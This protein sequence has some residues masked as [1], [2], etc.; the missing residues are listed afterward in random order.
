[1]NFLSLKEIKFFTP[2]LRKLVTPLVSITILVILFFVSFKIGF[3]K[4]SSQKEEIVGLNKNI[5]ILKKKEET[6]SIVQKNIS[7]SIQFFSMAIPASNPSLSI[8]SQIKTQSLLKGLIFENLKGGGESKGKS[9]SKVDI[10]FDLDG[11]LNSVLSFLQETE[12]FAPIITLEKIKLNQ[13]G[14]IYSGAINVRGYWADYPGK[15]PA[16]TQPLSDFS[17]EEMDMIVKISELLLPSFS[18]GIPETYSGR[19]EPF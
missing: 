10:N 12:K 4:L 8:I 7:N 18:E 11:D 19:T 15:I 1:M 13:S 2:N 16:I 17:D 5:G 6:L 3:S 14:G 9:F